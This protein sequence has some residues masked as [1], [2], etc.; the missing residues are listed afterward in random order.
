MKTKHSIGIICCKVNG[1]GAMTYRAPQCLFICK[2]YT[3]A[4][5]SF[6]HGNYRIE[7]LPE[8]FSKMTIDEKLDILSF[9]FDQIW[10]RV[11]LGTPKG[12]SFAQSKTR[13]EKLSVASILFF[14]RCIFL[15]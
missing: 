1:I 8:L 15:E 7:D 14:L 13:F 2:R 5:N 9:N 3:Y 12:A 4:Y 11:W 10:Y 6:V